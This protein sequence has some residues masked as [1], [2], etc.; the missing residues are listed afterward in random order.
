MIQSNN[1]FEDSHECS[2]DSDSCPVRR[3]VLESSLLFGSALPIRS[4]VPQ[5]PHQQ[6]VA[7]A[8]GAPQQHHPYYLLIVTAEGCP[9]CSSFK[10]KTLPRLEQELVSKNYGIEKIHL[11]STSAAIPDSYPTCLESFVVFF[12]SIILVQGRSWERT[13]SDRTAR[14]GARVFNTIKV[15]DRIVPRTKETKVQATTLPNIK[16]WISSIVDQDVS[17]SMQL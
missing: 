9:A 8:Q 12:P 17:L 13:R 10:E 16:N 5:Q 14:I 4:S 3:A 6:Q 2:S 11:P 7:T 1:S 15:D